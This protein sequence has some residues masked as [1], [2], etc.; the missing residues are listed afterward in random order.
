MTSTVWERR[1]ENE[2]QATKQGFYVDL[3]RHLLDHK[4]CYDQQNELGPL[5]LPLSELFAAHR[6]L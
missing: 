1:E 4:T 3:N 5:R 2:K 6:P